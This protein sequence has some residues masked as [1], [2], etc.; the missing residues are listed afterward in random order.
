MAGRLSL[1]LLLIVLGAP[2]AAQE[3]PLLL[4]A[5]KV[6]TM[7]GKPILNGEVLVQGGKIRAV[8]QDLSTPKDTVTVQLEDQFLLP[9]FVELHCHVGMSG[10][11]INDMVLPHNFELRTL[12]LVRIESPELKDAAGAGVTTVLMIPGSGSSIGGL[13]TLAKT[14]GAS[15]EERLI[16]FP[17]ALKIA[18]HARG[19]NPARRAGDLGSGRLGLHYMLKVVLKEA[20]DYH[21]A[22]VR[23]ETGKGDKPKFNARLDSLRGLFRREFPVLL[24]AYG[25]N[26]TMTA[27][28]VLKWGLDVDIILS[29]GVYDS[30]WIKQALAR[31]GVPMN[32]GPRQFEFED[33]KFMANAAELHGAGVPVSICTDAPVVRQDQ[34]PL[35]AAMAARLGLPTEAALR[36]LTIEP[37]RAIGLGDRL[38]SIKAGKDAD[39]VAFPGDPLDPRN[40]PT[41]VLINGK[42]VVDRR[43]AKQR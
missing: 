27:V 13:G 41:L 38:G 11:D 34:L 10:R 5:A 29:H 35:Q 6:L 30:Y 2:A 8:G 25:S 36:G 31:T 3:Q 26:D 28:R 7:E 14:A 16:R 24:H 40:L 33:G 32:L 23:F 37:A 39:L 19:G 20:R 42:I 15:F 12:D 22:W 18:L 43:Q 17:G 1:P 21:Q 9:G 4:R